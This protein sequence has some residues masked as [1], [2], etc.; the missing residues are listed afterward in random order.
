MRIEFWFFICIINV[1]SNAHAVGGTKVM[2]GAP[3]FVCRILAYDPNQEF[4]S[5]CSGSLTAVN[6]VTLSAHCVAEEKNENLSFKIGCGYL[7]ESD[8][9]D[10]RE[11]Q[12]TRLG[13]KVLVKGVKFIEEFASDIVEIDRRF[14]GDTNQ[15][16]M[17]THKTDVAK[18]ILNQ[19]SKK[20]QPVKTIE[21]AARLSTF[22][23]HPRGDKG[24][25]EM[26]ADVECRFSG[27]GLQSSRDYSGIAATV[28]V[29]FFFDSRKEAIFDYTNIKKGEVDEKNFDQF[30]NCVHDINNGIATIYERKKLLDDLNATRLFD[31]LIYPGDSGGPLYCRIKNQSSWVQVGVESTHAFY[32]SVKKKSL[33]TK[34]DFIDVFAILKPTFKETDYFYIPLRDWWPGHHA[35]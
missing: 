8:Q 11:F 4:V 25:Q 26:N 23:L 27:Y 10:E 17:D 22:F 33:S 29:N 31:H 20:I 19:E 12:N 35:N 34:K 13:T 9:P 6:E 14:I 2:D 28:P 15:Y 1:V 21:N 24:L 32:T 7:G 30:N 16:N 5:S 18:I 3:D